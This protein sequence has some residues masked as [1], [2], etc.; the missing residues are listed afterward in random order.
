M[1]RISDIIYIVFGVNI[2]VYN[3][4]RNGVG[5]GEKFRTEGDSKKNKAGL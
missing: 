2:F 1:G 4:E 3:N 5:S